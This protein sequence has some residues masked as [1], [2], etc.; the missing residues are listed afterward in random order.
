[1][2]S[3]Y[4]RRDHYASVFPPEATLDGR[5]I[6]ID[7]NPALRFERRISRSPERVWSALEEAKILALWQ[8]R[9]ATIEPKL[10]GH[11]YLAF[12]GDSEEMEGVITKWKPPNLLEFI[13]SSREAQGRSIVRF[14]LA[15]DGERCRLVLTNILGREDDLADFASGWHWQLDALDRAL[16]EETR[17]FERA[18]RAALRQMYAAT[19]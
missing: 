4:R 11:Y 18:R 8:P 10:G 12:H 13:S 3:W 14:E 2:A 5:R 19:L 16:H 7:G 17:A 6:E 1:M 15:S 9:P